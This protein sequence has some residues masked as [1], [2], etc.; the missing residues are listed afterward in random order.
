MK[1]KKYFTPL[2]VVYLLLLIG[3]TIYTFYFQNDYFPEK[4]NSALSESVK[5]TNMLFN[6]MVFLLFAISDAAAFIGSIILFFKSKKGFFLFIFSII[7]DLLQQ[8][9]TGWTPVTGLW[10]FIWAITSL[11]SASIIMIY[12]YEYYE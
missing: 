2:L 12:L 1:F 11:V 10:L 6:T 4:V 3:G 5:N 7:T 8:L 9:L